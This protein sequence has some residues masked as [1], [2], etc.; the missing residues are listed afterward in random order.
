M[1]R[2]KVL[3]TVTTYPLPSRS[4]DELVCTAGVL[5]NGKW[6]R[7]Y[8]VP[9]SFLIDLRGSGRVKNVKYNWVELN[10]K[11][12]ID[13]FRP[14]SYSP[15]H[16]D[17]KDLV[18]QSKLDTRSNWLRRKE[19]CLKNVYT[20]MADLIE[21]SRE[22]NN[23]SL[24]TFKPATIKCL[25]WK[26]DARDWKEVWKD[27]RKQ[28]DLFAEDK[29]PEILIPK[30][31]Y[32]FFYVFTDV[33]GKERTLMIEDWEIGALYWNCLRAAEGDEMMA[34]QKVKEKYEDEFINEK[35]IY[36]FLGTT[37]EWHMRRSTNP[38]VIIGVFYPKKEQQASLF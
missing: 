34:L 10:L 11:K 5:E 28:G 20:N 1:P 14:E 21:D 24:A 18:I 7:I 31:P 36:L 23:V 33:T 26:K 8:P 3:I 19:F 32:K 15:Q 30:L 6:I 2:H 38:F 13:D 27:L 37:K 16:A 9:L 29:S 17:F 22:P 35:D 12:R 25:K 4:Y